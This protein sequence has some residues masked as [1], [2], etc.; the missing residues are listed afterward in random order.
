MADSER[1]IALKVGALIVVAAALLVG[2]VVTLGN[3]S[4]RGDTASRSTSISPAACRG[5]RR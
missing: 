1:S 4:L 5:E 2:F 3:F